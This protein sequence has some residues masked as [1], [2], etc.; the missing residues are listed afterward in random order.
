MAD[1]HYVTTAGTLGAALVIAIACSPVAHAGDAAL[2][3]A[4]RATSN[5]DW[6]TT[7]DVYH[8]EA[9]SQSTWTI[10]MTCSDVVTCRGT[11][12]S[13]AGWSAEVFT[14][15]GEYVVKRDLPEWETCADGRKNTGHQRYRFFP[16]EQS[17]FLKPDS[18]VF[19]GFD[20][21]TGDSGNC[22]LNEKLEI[23][24]PFRLEKLN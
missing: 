2:N 15:G 11:V 17:G 24:V 22:S 7:N 21:T 10:A 5:G 13:D 23:A 9:S 3:G 1:R 14:L 20:V 19:A 8:D 6:A 4:F 16:V 18:G 12:T